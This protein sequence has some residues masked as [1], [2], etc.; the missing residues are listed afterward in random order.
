MHDVN[1]R[2]GGENCQGSM[3]ADKMVQINSGNVILDV[4]W[5][6]RADHD[7]CGEVYN[8]KNPVSTGLEVNGDNVTAY[9]LAVEH[10]IEDLVNWNGNHGQTYFYQSEFPY[11]VN[12][13]YGTKGYV[14][15]HVNDKVTS[16]QGHGIGAYS[17]FRDNW[18]N[19]KSG[20]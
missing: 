17:F 11:D 8:Y 1:A 9:G 13:S 12:A 5:L 3:Q 20:I 14:S 10:T 15:Y 7:S 18:V 4:N 6:W 19:V 2:V 16:H